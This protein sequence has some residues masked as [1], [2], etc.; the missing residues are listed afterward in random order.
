M[1][2][3]LKKWI[4]AVCLFSTMPLFAQDLSAP[5]ISK[6][7]V[8]LTTPNAV[9]N[10]LESLDSNFTTAQMDSAWKA[11]NNFTGTFLITLDSAID[12]NSVQIKIGNSADNFDIL[13]Q[14]ITTAHNIDSISPVFVQNNK[15]LN[16]TSS[17]FN[18]DS[19]LYYQIQCF[20]LYNYSS[21]IY[22]GIIQK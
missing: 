7:F 2:R 6:C 13:N 21:N 16:I 15:Y 5:I 10:T 11:N 12:I 20:D 19:S 4:L 18:V 22:S 8:A 9:T 3:T 17:N 14:T 1:I